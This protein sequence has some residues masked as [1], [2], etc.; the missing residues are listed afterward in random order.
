MNGEFISVETANKIARLEKE[1]QKLKKGLIKAINKLCEQDRRIEKA[2]DYIKGQNRFIEGCD[3]NL[4]T[5]WQHVLE[6]L[7]VSE[8]EIR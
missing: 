3:I 7:G 2:V 8:N 5:D 6:L 4:I 1:N